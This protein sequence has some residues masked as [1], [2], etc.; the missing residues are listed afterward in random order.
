MANCIQKE[1]HEGKQHAEVRKMNSLKILEN[2][3]KMEIERNRSLQ[4]GTVTCIQQ[5][6]I[7]NC[8]Y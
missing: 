6:H 5:G 1:I 3:E 8:S 2:M 4:T 7:T